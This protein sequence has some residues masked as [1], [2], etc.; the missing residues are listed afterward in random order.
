MK[1]DGCLQLIEG[2]R[3]LEGDDCEE[4]KELASQMMGAMTWCAYRMMGYCYGVLMEVVAEDLEQN[5]LTELEGLIFRVEHCQIDLL[6]GL[7]LDFLG[8]AQFRWIVDKWQDLLLAVVRNYP[9]PGGRDASDALL[10]ATT[11][12][13][14]FAYLL[15]QRRDADRRTKQTPVR[16]IDGLIRKPRNEF[17]WDYIRRKGVGLSTH[18]KE[19]ED[20]KTERPDAASARTDMP[21][22]T[23]LT[24]EFC[25]V[26]GSKIEVDEPIDLTDTTR[27]LFW[28]VCLRCDTLKVYVA[29]LNAMMGGVDEFVNLLLLVQTACT[30]RPP[31]LPR[32]LGVDRHGRGFFRPAKKSAG[33]SFFSC[34]VFPKGVEGRRVCRPTNKFLSRR[35]T[36]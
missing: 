32:F 10:K 6:A 20:A 8:R 5:G 3:D 35:S 22:I 31:P 26:C 13:E 18:P 28:G 29:N 34:G 33:G 14:L 11:R 7:P 25:P 12:L 27:A 16:S 2:G 36:I 21:E 23:P 24:S 1:S 4:A 15:R 17:H 19:I 30:G 9:Q